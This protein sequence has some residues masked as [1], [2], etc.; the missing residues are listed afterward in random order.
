MVD[1]F[2]LVLRKVRLL[3]GIETIGYHEYFHKIK[4]FIAINDTQQLIAS[5]LPE[6]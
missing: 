6:S 3:Y 4:H 2:N 1:H 5:Y